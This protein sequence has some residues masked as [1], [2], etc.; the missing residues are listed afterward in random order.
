MKLLQK[1][2]C[3]ICKTESCQVIAVGRDYEYHSIKEK[4]MLVQCGLCSHLYLNPRPSKNL[5]SMIYPFTYYTN[6]AK[7]PLFL[8]GFI[9]KRKLNSDIKRILKYGS[10]F[11]NILDI[12]CGNLQKLIQLKKKLEG[13]TN[14]TGLDLGF[15]DKTR[16]LAK[17]NNLNLIQGNVETA[18]NSLKG[19]YTIV[20]MSQLIEHL[21]DPFLALKTCND[22]MTKDGLLFIETP[23]PGG[24]DY[25]IFKNKYWGGYHFPRH[26][27]LFSPQALESLVKQSGFRIVT[28]GFLPSVGFWVISLRNALG[29]NSISKSRSLCEFINFRNVLIVGF[30]S[31][32]DYAILHFGGMTSNQFLICK[33]V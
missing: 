13:D 27:N 1:T 29:L 24:L 10:N 30:F 14:L 32:I 6:N 31:L 4:F 8:K 12:G 16:R 3:I 17:E 19:K 20:L 2:K 5:L 11:S 26:F 9:Y 28:S 33:K 15:S 21:Y 23:N 7:S 22:I 18:E 25:K